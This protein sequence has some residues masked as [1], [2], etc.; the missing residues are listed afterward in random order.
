[1]TTYTDILLYGQNNTKIITTLFVV[2][3]DA[4]YYKIVEMSKQFKL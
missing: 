3:N 4:H 1:M 2:P